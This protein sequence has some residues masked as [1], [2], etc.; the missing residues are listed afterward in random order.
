MNAASHASP[1]SSPS[2]NNRSAEWWRRVALVRLGAGPLAFAG[3]FLPWATG[4]GP[5]AA[6]DFT[7]FTLVGFAGRLQALDLS[8]TAG[9]TLWFARLAILGVA[10]A[11]AWQ[12]VLAPRHRRHFGYPASGWYLVA[13]ATVL[14]TIGLLRRGF[15]L[16]PSGF[17]LVVA[18]GL[19]FLLSWYV[20]SRIRPSGE[21]TE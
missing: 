14:V 4:P 15:T 7:G 6:T 17:T 2:R 20:E 18:A 3:F 8:V 10:I 19:C 16:P 5:F 1:A 13:A 12:T 9:A 11:A 21:P